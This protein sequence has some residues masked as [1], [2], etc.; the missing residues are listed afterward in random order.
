MTV[1]GDHVAV[2]NRILKTRKLKNQVGG[3]HHQSRSSR[4]PHERTTASVH[5][6]GNRH[7]SDSEVDRQHQK[8]F[9]E[10]RFAPHSIAPTDPRIFHPV[11]V[12]TQQSQC[13]ASRVSHQHDPLLQRPGASSSQVSG[14]PRRRTTD[15][16]NLS[17]VEHRHS[18]HKQ[19]RIEPGV[20]QRRE[21]SMSRLQQQRPT[22]L[23]L[24][25]STTSG[26]SKHV[27]PDSSPK[28][29]GYASHSSLSPNQQC[30]ANILYKGRKR[31]AHKS[32]EEIKS[33]RQEHKLTTPVSPTSDPAPPSKRPRIRSNTTSGSKGGLRSDLLKKMTKK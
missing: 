29:A 11:S 31:V 15:T 26:H 18:F 12:S 21:S 8:S 1:K 22:Q 9:P 27:S 13:A 32:D 23:K 33:Q 3:D 5:R 7:R 28:M 2:V 16:A 6:Q 10:Q 4:V 17:R 20:D 14:A 19:V 25:T 30:H 24:S